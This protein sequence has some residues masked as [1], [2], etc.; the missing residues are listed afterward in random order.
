MKSNRHAA[1]LKLI[2]EHDITS[3][4]ELTLKL[5]DAGFHAAQSTISRD[6]RELGLVLERF[7][8]GHK[9]VATTQRNLSVLLTDSLMSVESA[10]HMLVL[11]TRSGMAMAV[12]LAIDE[13][14]FEEMLGSVAGDDTVLCVVRTPD[15]AEALKDKLEV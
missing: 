11:R 1:I 4:S 3:Q 8:N 2:R 9:Y 15:E 12:A 14:E 13:M 5:A 7:T 6:I 10:G